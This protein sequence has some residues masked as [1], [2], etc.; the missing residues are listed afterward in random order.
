M[1][2]ESYFD[3]ALSNFVFDF[4]SGGAIR[5]LADL[6]YTVT[7]I[8]GRL[9]FPTPKERVAEAVWKHY[10]NIGKIRLDKSLN[11]GVIEKISYVKEQG[12]YGRTSMR[13]V[14]EKVEAPMKSY[15][16]C[17]FGKNITH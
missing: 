9:D 15:I 10:I 3:K 1:S 14:V 5:H 8:V 13:R 12:K 16:A 2:E 4:A 17:D 7:E 6:G 11:S